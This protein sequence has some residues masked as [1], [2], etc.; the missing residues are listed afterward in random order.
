M[1]YKKNEGILFF[2]DPPPSKNAVPAEKTWSPDVV[3]RYT[4]TS[5]VKLL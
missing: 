3:E 4:K 2:Q 5:D 1:P